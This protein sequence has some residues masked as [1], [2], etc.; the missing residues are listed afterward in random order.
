M[1][2][3]HRKR[4]RQQK[5]L[6][7]FFGGR[8][9]RRIIEDPMSNAIAIL[10]KVVKPKE[11][12]RRRPSD[13][14]CICMEEYEFMSIDEITGEKC[15]VKKTAK[16]LLCRAIYTLWRKEKMRGKNQSGPSWSGVVRHLESVHNVRTEE[17]AKEAMAR[18]RSRVRRDATAVDS[19][20]RYTK[21]WGP[22]SPRFKEC[23]KSVAKLCA[24]ENLPLHLG[25][26]PG[27][28]TF[29]RTVD[30]RYPKI[31][32]R[33]VMRSVED[34]ADE[35]V[36]SIRSTM[37]QACAVTDVSFTC[38]MWSSVAN[39]QYLTVTLHWLDEKWD[40]QTI[41]LGTMEFNVRHTKHNISK[42]MLKVRSKFGIFPRAEVIEDIPEFTAS[43]W[44]ESQNLGF[45]FMSG[46]DCYGA[47]NA[48]DRPSITTDCG[49]NVS[50]G[51]ELK[52]L[53]DWNKCACHM[54]H[55]AVNAGLNAATIDVRL[56]PLYKLCRR[57]SRS[58]VAWKKFK[59]RQQEVVGG[60]HSECENEVEVECGESADAADRG[61]L[62]LH[63]PVKTRWNSV[64][65][66]INRA[67]ELKDAITRFSE[68]DMELDGRIDGEDDENTSDGEA[69]R[70]V[71]EMVR[72]T[73]PH[74]LL[75]LYIY[76][77]IYC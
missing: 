45:D 20:Q 75:F 29:M 69:G 2:G 49:A 35:V 33:S 21:P 76:I 67:L 12:G 37:S 42:A 14:C 18:Q 28:T 72:T 3:G 10:L 16:C 71:E 64:F 11:K 68:N 44:R 48:L 7:E 56:Q 53:W 31:S 62:R 13:W 1:S 34:Q 8:Y 5:L 43:D 52:N 59:K 51:V 63:A 24:W 58:S 19:I 47:E 6:G 36:K 66:C 61:A 30:P 46:S 32:R 60:V 4:H 39:D 9:K 22:K 77:H 54:L 38:D 26:R 17:E 55:L 23:V 27:F 74:S 57:L 73:H 15:C 41:I 50:A 25:E 40:M 70:V 65:D